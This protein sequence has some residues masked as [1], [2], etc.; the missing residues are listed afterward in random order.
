MPMKNRERT[1]TLDVRD[2]LARGV[3]PFTRIMSTV[4]SL[5]A[6]EQLLLIAP[7]EPKPLF[8]IMA[9]RGFAYEVKAIDNGD[10]EVRFHR[11]QPC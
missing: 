7:F 3:E 6:D 9:L 10:Y 1:V 5:Q 2:D 11:H 4:A 8:E